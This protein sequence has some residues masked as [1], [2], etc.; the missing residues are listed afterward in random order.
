MLTKLIS[1][2]IINASVNKIEEEENII[3][4]IVNAQI[5]LIIAVNDIDNATSPLEKAV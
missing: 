3:K 4:G 5:K 1:F 2:S